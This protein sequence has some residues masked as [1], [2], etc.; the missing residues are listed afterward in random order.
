MSERVSRHSEPKALRKASEKLDAAAAI[1]R[2]RQKRRTNGGNTG[3]TR[4]GR[5]K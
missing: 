4:G 2:Q 1:T 5:Q 3:E